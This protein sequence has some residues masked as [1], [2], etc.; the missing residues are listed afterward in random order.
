MRSLDAAE[1][2]FVVI[3]LVL[4]REMRLAHDVLDRNVTPA[5]IAVLSA[6]EGTF[7]GKIDDDCRAAFKTALSDRLQ[8][9]YNKNGTV[10]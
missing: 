5:K 6:A 8:A 2:N 9:S 4:K 1:N 3:A 7:H 10:G